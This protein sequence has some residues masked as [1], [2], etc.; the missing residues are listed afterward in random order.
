M[1]NSFLEPYNYYVLYAALILLIIFLIYTAIK[2]SHLLKTVNG[3]KESLK[4]VNNQV[5]MAK[6]K[7]DAMQEKKAEDKKKDKIA[8]VVIPFL[9]YAYQLYKKD[10]DLHG[11]KGYGKAMTKAAANRKEE[12]R[13]IQKIKADL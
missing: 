1:N 9:L 4:P 10:D 5:T 2:A 3:M 13:I 6:I 7:V 8:A 11:L 12:Q